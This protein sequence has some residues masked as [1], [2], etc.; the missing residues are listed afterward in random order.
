[1]WGRQ[2]TRTGCRRL[3]LAVA[4]ASGQTGILDLDGVDG[5]VELEPGGD[6]DD[7]LGS[8]GGRLLGG[9]GDGRQGWVGNDRL[10]GGTTGCGDGGSDAK[11]EIDSDL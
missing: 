11:A 10:G 7:R 5:V 8:G 6:G 2:P 9:S 1:M 4:F 3:A